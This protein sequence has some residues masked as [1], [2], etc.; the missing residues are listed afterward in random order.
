MRDAPAEFQAELTRIG[1]VNQYNEPIF[2]LVWSTDVRMVIGGRFADGFVGYREKMLIPGEPCWCLMIY[3]DA[4]TLGSVE[5]WERDYRDP[6]TGLFDCGSFPR[7]GRYRLLRKLMHSERV[8]TWKD[9]IVARGDGV[10]VT[11]PTQTFHLV[12]H[13]MKPCGLILDLMLPM[14]MAW[15]KLSAEMKKAAVLAQSAE[16]QAEYLRMAKDAREGCRVKRGWQLVQK[17][18]EQIEKGM[19]QAMRVASQWGLGMATIGD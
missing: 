17:R 18:A 5:S 10:L 11:Q 12:H 15:R 1:G 3:E 14:L 7:Y 2:K 8:G 13:K 6:E 16:R 4:S 19:E 9:E